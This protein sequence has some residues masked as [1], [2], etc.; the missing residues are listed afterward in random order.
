MLARDG[1]CARPPVPH[2]AARSYP[3]AAGA[4]RPQD[5]LHQPVRL[6]LASDHAG[7]QTA[8]MGRTAL[9]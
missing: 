4:K 9:L 8:H 7:A 1:A 5:Q 3:S 6:P 2:R